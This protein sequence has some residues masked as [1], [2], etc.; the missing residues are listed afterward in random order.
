MMN[1]LFV[2]KGGTDK[3]YEKK[4]IRT[5]E[6]GSNR[7]KKTFLFYLTIESMLTTEQGDVDIYIFKVNCKILFMAISFTIWYYGTERDF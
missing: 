1:T 4:Q 3:M 5:T 7:E 6:K 2:E